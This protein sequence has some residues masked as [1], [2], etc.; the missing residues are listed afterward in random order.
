MELKRPV[1]NIN[2]APLTDFGSPKGKFVAKLARM[3]PALGAKRMGAMLTIIEPGKCAFPFHKHHAIE[4]MFFILEGKG[5][6]RY[7]TKS[8]SIKSGDLLSAP[9]DE[10]AEAHQIVNTGKERLKFLAFSTME[11]VDIVEYPDSN[12]FRA[13]SAGADGDLRNA[14]F[15][16]LTIAARSVDLFEG[17]E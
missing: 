2:D 8:H 3:G 13:Y 16:S 10:G 4:E 17:E 5:R 11:G 6:Y 7:G 1:L 14:R 12:K 15:N 9:V